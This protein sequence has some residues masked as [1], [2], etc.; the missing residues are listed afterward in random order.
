MTLVLKNRWAE[1]ALGFLLPFG[2]NAISA[3]NIS[4]I[5]G[6]MPVSRQGFFECHL[7]Q[8]GKVDFAIPVSIHNNQK[9]LGQLARLFPGEMYIGQ[10]LTGGKL[11]NHN[12]LRNI[13][14]E[15]DTSEEECTTPA[16]VFFDLVPAVSKPEGYWQQLLQDVLPFTGTPHNIPVT[17]GII[18]QCIK[19][20]NTGFVTHIGVMTGRGHELRLCTKFASPIGVMDYLHGTYYPLPQQTMDKLAHLLSLADIACVNYDF[21]NGAVQNKI[22]IELHVSKNT[23]NQTH[24]ES[25]FHYLENY[26]LC[27]R[28]QTNSLIQW[29]QDENKYNAGFLHKMSHIKITLENGYIQ[30]AKAYVNYAYAEEY[31]IDGL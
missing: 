16:G 3:K 4:K 10:F 29:Q 25:L 1:H 18:L 14:L 21:D 17:I 24:L 7:A 6:L 30:T 9:E 19:N 8:P 2:V 22:G 28:P 11:Y 13:W 23:G 27:S 15:F 20:I 12:S 26:G 5:A 31:R